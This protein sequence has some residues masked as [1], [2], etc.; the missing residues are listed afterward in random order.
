MGLGPGLKDPDL[1]DI[2]PGLDVNSPLSCFNV[3]RLTLGTNAL[4]LGVNTL[5][6]AVI[7]RIFGGNSRVR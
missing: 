2:A 7:T 1:D 4:A 3:F 6:F 5:I